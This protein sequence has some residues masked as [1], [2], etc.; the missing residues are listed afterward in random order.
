MFSQ[1]KSIQEYS[2]AEIIAASK[3]I[4]ISD[5]LQLN[6]LSLSDGFC[7]MAAPR[8][9]GFDGVFSSFHGGLL[10][11]LA[12]NAACVA[13]MTRLGLHPR[14]ATTDMSIRFLAPC[15]SDAVAK[16]RIVKMG[17]SL[18]LVSV[19]LFDGSGLH[20]AVAQVSYILLGRG[21][22]ASDSDPGPTRRQ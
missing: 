2:S 15:R 3:R 11:T 20:I 22:R 16:A 13:L 12:D 10:M 14:M 17:R 7:E 9:Q 5:T 18:A 6:I 8:L 4:P 1:E 19:D 21:R